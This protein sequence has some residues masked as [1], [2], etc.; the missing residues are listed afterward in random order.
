MPPTKYGKY[1]SREIIEESKYPKVTAPMVKFRGNRGGKDLT[2]EYSC[3]TNPLVMD[4]EPEVNDF[5]QFMYFGS[6]NIEDLTEF[7]AE[8][9]LPLGKEGKKQIINHP[10]LVYIPQGL[11]HGPVKFK[12]IKKP[13]VF[14]NIALSSKYSSKWD[15]P[16]YSKYV[17][18]PDTGPFV[19]QKPGDPPTIQSIHPR[20]TPFR[21]LRN[22]HMAHVEFWGK[23]LG[24]PAQLCFSLMGPKYREYAY[25]EAWHYHTQAPQYSFFI[26]GNPLNLR[27][28]MLK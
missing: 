27:N 6:G 19:P 11:V 17:A 16:D 26:G 20:G 2:F 21:Y 25:L 8:I 3:I 10:G 18:K 28:L 12:S 22:P 7:Q 14:M 13:I 23:P 15:E 1:I 24:W 5:D 4:D 9:E